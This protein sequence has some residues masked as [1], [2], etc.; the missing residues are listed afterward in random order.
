M[1]RV[2]ILL[3]KQSLVEKLQLIYEL[4]PLGMDT[5][6]KE[7]REMV[8]NLMSFINQVPPSEENKSY[9]PRPNGRRMY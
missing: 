8:F 7:L 4:L 5:Q 2:K 3:D 1:E 9:Y 6:E